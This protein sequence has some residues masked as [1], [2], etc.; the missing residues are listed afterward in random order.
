MAEYV[1]PSCKYCG[2]RLPGFPR[3]L[4]M[5]ARCEAFVLDYAES[6][7][8]RVPSIHDLERYAVLLMST[9]P[10]ETCRAFG[11]SQRLS[12]GPFSD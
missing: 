12:N 3:E 2:C 7:G 10:L 11:Y 5:C 1:N 4:E 9:V 6:H 8:G